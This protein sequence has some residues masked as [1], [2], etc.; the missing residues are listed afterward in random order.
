MWTIFH[1][2]CHG[3]ILFF[4]LSSLCVEKFEIGRAKVF[5]V[6]LLIYLLRVRFFLVLSTFPNLDESSNV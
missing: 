1:L 2:R 3:D 6:V 5:E 4:C